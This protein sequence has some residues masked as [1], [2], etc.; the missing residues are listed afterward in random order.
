VR[1][2]M[3]YWSMDNLYNAAVFFATALISRR[4][5]RHALARIESEARTNESLMEVRKKVAMITHVTVATN[6]LEAVA[7]VALGVIEA[8]GAVLNLKECGRL[9]DD[10]LPMVASG[11]LTLEILV[12]IGFVSIFKELNLEV[13]SDAGSSC[14]SMSDTSSIFDAAKEDCHGDC[15]LEEGLG[16]VQKGEHDAACEGV[17]VVGELT[18]PMLGGSPS[19]TDMSTSAS[20]SEQP[21]NPSSATSLVPLPAR[22]DALATQVHKLSGHALLTS[23]GIVVSA[24]QRRER[25]LRTKRGAYTPSVPSIVVQQVHAEQVSFAEA[26]AV[27]AASFPEAI[28]RETVEALFRLLHQEHGG[29]LVIVYDPKRVDLCLSTMDGG[30]LKACFG[31]YGRNLH[32]DRPNFVSI[33]R[34]FRTHSATDRWE[35]WLLQELAQNLDLCTP[36][37][38]ELTLALAQLEGQPKDGAILVSLNGTVVG[39]AQKL[40]NSDHNLE[41]IRADAKGVGTRH[42]AGLGAVHTLSTAWCDESVDLGPPGVVLVASDNGGVSIMLPTAA[43]VPRILQVERC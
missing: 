21:S 24:A 29:S 34:A 28:Q 32:H 30:K 35:R 15:A 39:A 7:L 14:V 1:V 2:F 27:L 11:P 10:L 37:T 6:I 23:P 20:E 41:M 9:R 12:L 19:P 17:G 26:S 5:M 18:S 16:V 3:G 43:E 13:A 25:A 36:G 42:T 31:K 8:L 33:L 22:R 4:V 38:T 40:R